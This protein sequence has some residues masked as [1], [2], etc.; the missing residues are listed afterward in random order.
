MCAFAHVDVHNH[1]L[2]MQH[3]A[4]LGWKDWAPCQGHC[5]TFTVE[6]K[7]ACR[8][9]TVQWT[10]KSSQSHNLYCAALTSTWTLAV[11]H[12]QLTWLCSQHAKSSWVKLGILFSLLFPVFPLFCLQSRH[13]LSCR[14]SHFSQILFSPFRSAVSVVFVSLS[15]IVVK[16][17]PLWSWT[18]P[19]AEFISLSRLCVCVYAS[20]H[21]CACFAC[22]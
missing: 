15:R 4:I 9:L 17:V 13:L 2:F 12:T 6:L 22:V 1:I 19:R 3:N 5:L 16:E 8:A 11:A 18:P 10:D 14:A 7:C 20:C 21:V